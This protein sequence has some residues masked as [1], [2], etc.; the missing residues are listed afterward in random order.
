MKVFIAPASSLQGS[1]KAPSSKNYSTRYL[2]ISALTNGESTIYSPAHNDDARA[3]ISC[4]QNLGA[5]IK[6][7]K[8]YIKIKGFGRNP[9]DISDLNPENGGLVL[10]LLLALGLFLREVRYTTRFQESLGKRPQGDLLAALRLLGAEVEDEDGHLPITIR[11][12]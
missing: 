2:W 3:L 12:G 7:G 10:R 1:V 9:D 11:G 5:D 4:C 8:D 6:E